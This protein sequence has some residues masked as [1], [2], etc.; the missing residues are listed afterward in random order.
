MG[1]AEKASIVNKMFS[2]INKKL[3][4]VSTPY[5]VFPYKKKEDLFFSFDPPYDL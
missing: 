2:L 1:L 5:L 4:L 3:K